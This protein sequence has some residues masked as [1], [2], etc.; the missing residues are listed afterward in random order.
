[1]YILWNLFYFLWSITTLIWFLLISYYIYNL[2]IN[3]KNEKE[4]DGTNKSNN[5]EKNEKNNNNKNNIANFIEKFNE[6]II[7]ILKIDWTKKMGK[8]EKKYYSIIN[9][10]II[11][12]MWLILVFISNIFYNIYF[13]S[14]NFQIENTNSKMFENTKKQLEIQKNNWLTAE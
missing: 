6:K 2:I 10:I 14:V 9:W 1:M 3:D 8:I 11:F 12:A 13:N 7:S 5:K 4:N